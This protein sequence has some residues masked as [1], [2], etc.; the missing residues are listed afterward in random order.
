M[1]FIAT[2]A[3]ASDSACERL[4]S[5][6]LQHNDNGVRLN[7]EFSSEYETP[8]FYRSQLLQGIT[9]YLFFFIQ[10]LPKYLA[11]A[12]TDDISEHI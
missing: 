5:N 2:D 1:H 7:S 9:I 10:L 12:D 8:L 4:L 3:S 11:D 6:R